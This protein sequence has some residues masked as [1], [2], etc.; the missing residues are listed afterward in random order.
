MKHTHFIIMIALAIIL[1]GCEAQ[2]EIERQQQAIAEKVC[3]FDYEISG[4]TLTVDDSKVN[5]IGGGITS[6]VWY[7]GDGT[8]TNPGTYP[9]MKLSHTY[10]A[11][12]TYDVTLKIQWINSDNKPAVYLEKSCTKSITLE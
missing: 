6:K 12:G 8:M 2:N 1:C 4:L 11:A 10:V 5:G 3:D 9:M 7:W